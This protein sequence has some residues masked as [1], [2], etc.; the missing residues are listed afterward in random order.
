[1]GFGAPTPPPGVT[2]F[3]ELTDTPATYAGQALKLAKVNVGETALSLGLLLSFTDWYAGGAPTS[4]PWVY[5][6][7]V[8]FAGGMK[9]SP[10]ILDGVTGQ[11]HVFIIGGSDEFYKYNIDTKQ[12][13][14]LT[15][16]P[17]GLSNHLALSPDGNKLASGSGTRISI[18]DIEANTWSESPVAPQISA[19]DA[20]M[21]GCVWAD[22]DVIWAWV[23]A[24]VTGTWTIKCYKYTVSTSTWNAYANSITPDPTVWATACSIRTDGT[25]VY[26]SSLGNNYYSF[27]RY[28]IATDAYSEGNFGTGWYSI[29]G[30]DRKARLWVRQL[31]GGDWWRF[32]DCD[33]DTLTWSGV[34]D[35][36]LQDKASNLT[37]G[38]R[39]MSQIIYHARN[40]NPKIMSYFGTGSWRLAQKVLTDYNLVVFRKPADGFAI[41][42]VN[43]TAGYYI[44][45]HLFDVL[46]LP[47][48]TWEFFYPKD[49]DYTKLKI[50][51]SE[52][53]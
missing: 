21:M 35:N 26:A 27:Q 49:G 22:N 2:T 41:S 6:P 9:F 5:E 46:C 52:L 20:E 40:D 36:T 25:T 3:L 48:G 50:S 31:S 30:C 33:A 7:D 23:R 14:K 8:P 10:I 51:G 4:F 37:G 13:H 47:A 19:T 45:I 29:G 17:G 15:D 12:Y 11:Y 44:P 43:V 24:D 18:Y 53:K 38:F 32:W 1:M 34:E 16:A 39:E 28:T 42:C